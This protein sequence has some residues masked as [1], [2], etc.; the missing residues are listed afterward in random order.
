MRVHLSPRTATSYIKAW[1][2]TTQHPLPKIVGTVISKVCGV[3]LDAR[4]MLIGR[5]SDYIVR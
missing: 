2:D 5:Q 3:S 1:F 4:R